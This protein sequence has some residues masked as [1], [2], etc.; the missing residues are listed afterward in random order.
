MSKSSLPTQAAEPPIPGIYGRRPG[1]DGVPSS[2]RVKRTPGEQGSIWVEFKSYEAAKAYRLTQMLARAASKS[3]KRPRE[4]A[5]PLSVIWAAW[6][7]SQKHLRKSSKS[8]YE[9]TYRHIISRFNHIEQMDT[10]SVLNIFKEQNWAAN[11]RRKRLGVLKSFVEWA[12]PAYRS[13][14]NINFVQLRFL[15]KGRDEE[16]TRRWLKSEDVHKIWEYLREHYPTTFQMVQLCCC[17]GMRGDEVV[18]MDMG[19][20]KGRDVVLPAHITKSGR[21]RTVPVADGFKRAI[22][23]LRK[24]TIKKFSLD[25]DALGKDDAPLWI[26]ATTGTIRAPKNTMKAR[27]G[28]ACR[29]NDI[30]GKPFHRTRAYALHFLVNECGFN[31]DT[32]VR[33]ILGWDSEAVRFYINDAGEEIADKGAMIY[34]MANAS[35]EIFKRPSQ[36]LAQFTAILE[37]RDMNALAMEAKVGASWLRYIKGRTLHPTINQME[38]VAKSLGYSLAVVKA[39]AQDDAPGEKSARN[40]RKRTETGVAGNPRRGFPGAV[41]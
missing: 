31:L 36:L 32:Q 11:T 35:G 1:T 28:I 39:E 10:L 17:Y 23:K 4:D 41:R 34:E 38:Q 9:L 27:Y 22:L 18:K 33:P 14:I 26:D 16:R 7:D 25:A 24:E 40:G 15:R 2:W 13:R 19:H 12:E 5:Q 6:L 21:S 8:V 30:T 37:G 29:E 3:A 20:W